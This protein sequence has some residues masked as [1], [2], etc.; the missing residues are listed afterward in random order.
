[1]T[2]DNLFFFLDQVGDRVVAFLPSPVSVENAPTPGGLSTL[3][4]V[5]EFHAVRLST[6]V[7]CSASS[8]DALPP[9]PLSSLS[10]SIVAILPHLIQAIAALHYHAHLA[11]GESILLLNA[12][13][14]FGLIL[15]QLATAWGL[16]VMAVTDDHDAKYRLEH[17][18]VEGVGKSAD[19]QYP[20]L[21]VIDP[22][23][24][25]VGSEGA[26]VLKNVLDE[27][28]GIGVDCILDIP[29]SKRPFIRSEDE[30][31]DEA[32]V[33]YVT[34]R[35]MISCL[36][37]GGRWITGRASLQL[38]PPESEVLFF[39]GA[40]LSFLFN[41][42]LLCPSQLG[43]FHHVVKKALEMIESGD[44]TLDVEVIDESWELVLQKLNDGNGR[45]DLRPVVFKLPP[46]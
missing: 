45:G 33:S 36:A 1:M 17:L 11:A 4:S 38:D 32:I 6:E 23:H 37:A 35:D 27:T 2:T 9:P 42:W 15:A 25:R 21:R 16:K 40:S 13:T 30:K 7:V 44:I 41:H 26:Y 43:R 12:G 39:K 5:F 22:S 18:K 46:F 8:S 3:C 28:N 14:H 19:S 10:P 24:A 29:P 34:Q 31:V 20:A